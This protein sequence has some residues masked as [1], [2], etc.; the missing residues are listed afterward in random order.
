MMHLN[1]TLIIMILIVPFILMVISILDL[2]KRNFTGPSDKVLWIFLIVLIPLIGS[3]AYLI[4][5]RKASTRAS[6][7]V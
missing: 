6:R 4:I 3:L 1:E 7:S 2:M 5:G